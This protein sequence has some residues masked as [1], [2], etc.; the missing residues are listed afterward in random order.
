MGL[1]S[2]GHEQDAKRAQ[3]AY[4]A[5]VREHGRNSD[6]AELAED[7]LVQARHA[8]ASARELEARQQER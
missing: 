2:K 7:R 4:K 5:A 6:E 1:F 3:T 8:A